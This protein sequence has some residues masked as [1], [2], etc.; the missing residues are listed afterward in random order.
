MCHKQ[1]SWT[2]LGTQGYYI[3][4]AVHTF[5]RTAN[6]NPHYA[7]FCAKKH[8]WFTAKPAVSGAKAG[9]LGTATSQVAQKETTALNATTST[10][11]LAALV[12]VEGEPGAPEIEA[13]TGSTP[14]W[15]LACE[16]EDVL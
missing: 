14:D 1:A 13:S 9:T 3:Q 10:D 7:A 12:Q 11:E 8:A 16:D 2:I 4:E 5:L 6:S 15:A